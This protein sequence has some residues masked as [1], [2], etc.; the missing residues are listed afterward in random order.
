[1]LGIPLEL[2]DLLLIEC[3]LLAKGRAASPET[4]AANMNVRI[5]YMDNLM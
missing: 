1:M 4:E 2:D 3:P 5:N